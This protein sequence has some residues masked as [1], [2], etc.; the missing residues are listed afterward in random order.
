[1]GINWAAVGA[2]VS[3]FV[4][5]ITISIT[6]YKLYQ[7]KKN[8]NKSKGKGLK[9]QIKKET[10]KRRDKKKGPRILFDDI[11]HVEPRSVETRKIF[12][13]KKEIVKISVIEKNKRKFDY[14]LFTEDEYHKSLNK[15][16]SRK[17]LNKKGNEN[18][19]IEIEITEEALHYF[20]FDCSMK[21]ID[22]DI[23][24][25]IHQIR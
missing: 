23:H 14:L 2:I 16:R 4:G 22:R 25:T 6:M 21:K 15:G 19:L 8:P 3:A 24:L 17:V 1:M 9:K 18:S 13:E 11:I 20:V 5:A 12:F 10:I 7:F